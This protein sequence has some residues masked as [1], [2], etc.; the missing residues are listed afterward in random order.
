MRRPR[1]ASEHQIRHA[2]LA[3]IG[4][5]AYAKRMASTR[6][7]RA[8]AL[9]AG[10]LTSARISGASAPAQAYTVFWQA[11]TSLRSGLD[12]FYACLTEGSS[13]SPTWA[14][15]FGV[16]SVSYRGSYVLTSTLPATVKLETDLQTVMTG[17]FD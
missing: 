10:L 6:L 14:S 11:D 1:L 3:R 8:V 13:F 2:T 5:W 16:S 15:Q 9:S 17:A 12:A 7:L 4:F